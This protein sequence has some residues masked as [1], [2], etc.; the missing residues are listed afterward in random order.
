MDLFTVIGGAAEQSIQTDGK[1]VF[2]TV[3]DTG[4]DPQ[5]R[6]P[7]RRCTAMSGTDASNNPLT[8]ELW[9][10]TTF[11]F[12]RITVPTASITGEA[13]TFDPVSGKTGT[14]DSFTVD[15][16]RNTVSNGGSLGTASSSTSKAKPSAGSAKSAKKPAEK[17]SKAKKKASTRKGAR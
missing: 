15:L 3:G 7:V 2:H 4:G 14:G 6:V 1:I 5:S 12:L 8:L 9:N 13:V 10:D 17:S 16:K 11:G